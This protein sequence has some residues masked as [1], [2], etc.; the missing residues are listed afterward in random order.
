MFIAL[1]GGLLLVSC[2][3]GLL[4]AKRSKDTGW[5]HCPDASVIVRSGGV[6]PTDR[7]DCRHFGYVLYQYQVENQNYAG[8]C[9]KD[10]ATPQEA[11]QFVVQ[12]RADKLVVRFKPESPQDSCLFVESEGGQELCGTSVRFAW[13]PDRPT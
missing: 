12:C 1:M 8:L 9:A 11:M 13:G 2:G 5:T 3:T 7:G 6:R 4:V 10:F